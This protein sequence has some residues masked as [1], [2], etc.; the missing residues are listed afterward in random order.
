MPAPLLDLVEI[1]AVGIERVVGLLIG[2]AI[3]RAT[4]ALLGLDIFEPQHDPQGR[5]DLGN[6]LLSFGHTTKQPGELAQ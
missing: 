2:S 4:T 1:R 6:V 3:H 5:R